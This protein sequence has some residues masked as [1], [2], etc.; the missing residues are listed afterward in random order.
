MTEPKQGGVRAN[1]GKNRL[2][3]ISPKALWALGEV[4]TMGAEKYAPRN[5]ERGLSFSET[6][7]ALLRHLYKWLDGHVYDEESG[8]HHLAHVV[9][10]AVA[11]LHFNLDYDYYDQFDDRSD[12]RTT[13]PNFSVQETHDETDTTV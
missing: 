6:A 9:W 12:C 8:L 7:D 13:L 1:R 3:L 11:L 4:Y 2:S 5:W 10:N